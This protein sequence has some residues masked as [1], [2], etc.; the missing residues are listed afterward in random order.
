[1]TANLHPFN[2]SL[3]KIRELRPEGIILSG[4]PASVYQADAPLSDPRIAE[5]GVPVLGICYGMGVLAKED[6]A[7]T[8][9]AHARE[10][11]RRS[12]SSTT[13]RTSSRVSASATRRRCG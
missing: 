1:M 12:G 8:A 3:D 10:V 2:L 5:L 4:G 11:G 7:R 13:T 9:R 6:G